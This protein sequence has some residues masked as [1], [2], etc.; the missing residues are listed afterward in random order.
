MSLRIWVG[1]YLSAGAA[2]EAG[3]VPADLLEAGRQMRD[4]LLQDLRA[5][6]PG[7]GDAEAGA[8]ADAPLPAAGHEAPTPRSA[9]PRGGPLCVSYAHGPGVSP[10]AGLAAAGSV[11]LRAI[12]P[13][14]G[15]TTL[16][17]LALE[18]RHH[19]LAWLVAPEIGGAL[20]ALA[21][22]VGPRRWVGSMPEAIAV[23]GSKRAMLERLAAGGLLTPLA[24]DG[25]ARAWVVKPDD[26][27]GTTDTRRH[28]S[29][30]RAEADLVARR[31]RGE[32]T[33]LEPWVDGEAMSLSLRCRRGGAPELLAINRQRIE[34]DAA[35]LLR[36]EGVSICAVPLDDPRAAALRDLAQGVVRALPGLRG[37]VGIDFVWNAQRGPVVI[38]VNPRLTCA[39]AGL[40]AALGRSLAAEILADHLHEQAEDRPAEALEAHDAA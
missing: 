35:G 32:P 13:R 34:S 11:T 2:A 27:A 7:V 28:A 12:A 40:S 3:G 20:E 29:R 30:A 24:L 10:P 19:D 25:A 9:A 31:E 36:D 4:A 16:D 39:F 5:W 6:S 1:E 18:A 26:G 15:E 14:P 33:T 22:A 17:F 23:A 38:E 8:P 21:R 37:F